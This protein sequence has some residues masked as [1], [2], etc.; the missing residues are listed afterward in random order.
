MNILVLFLLFFVRRGK[1]KRWRTKNSIWG[2]RSWHTKGDKGQTILFVT[3]LKTFIASGGREFLGADSEVSLSKRV[4]MSKEKQKLP[5][6]PRQMININETTIKLM[7]LLFVLI[8]IRKPGKM[9][10]QTKIYWATGKTLCIR[11]NSNMKQVCEKTQQYF[12]QAA[13]R[14]GKSW[15]KLPAN[16]FN[17]VEVCCRW[18]IMKKS[19]AKSGIEMRY[20][21][22]LKA[23]Q[24]KAQRSFI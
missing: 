6:R 1:R 5:P 18:K 4:S 15:T 24:L 8:R 2:S 20:V 10:A 3:T 21:W 11:S 13:F 19:K 17:S 7:L 22:G 9:L 12:E 16:D 14:A 23:L